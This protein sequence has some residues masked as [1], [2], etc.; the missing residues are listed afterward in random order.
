MRLVLA[1]IATAAMLAVPTQASAW[2]CRADGFG[3]TRDG[4][5]LTPERAKFTALRRCERNSALHLCTIRWCNR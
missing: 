3:S 1:A 4:Y 2:V 5:G